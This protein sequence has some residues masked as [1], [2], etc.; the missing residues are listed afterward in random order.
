MASE[1]V[2]TSSCPGASE[3]GCVKRDS[4][5]SQDVSVKS[6]LLECDRGVPPKPSK[7]TWNSRVGR[8]PDAVLTREH[9]PVLHPACTL[10]HSKQLHTGMETIQCT[11]YWSTGA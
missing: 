1:V 11:P 4:R 3:V 6:W 5:H 9:G 7:V 2:L 8:R 10:S